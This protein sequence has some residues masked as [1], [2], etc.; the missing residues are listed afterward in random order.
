M[1]AKFA[2]EKS[3]L[4]EKYNSATATIA[5]LNREVDELRQYQQRVT[6]EERAAAEDAV[7]A[8]FGDLN[9]VEAFDSLRA[10][11]SEMSIEDIEEKCFAIRG[12]VNTKVF[13]VEKPKQTRLPIDK[14]NMSNMSDEPYGGLFVEFPPSR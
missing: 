5:E 2:A 14:R 8:R 10:N 7:F 11:C 1:N 3:D 12:R 9:G 6:A 13:S 4:E